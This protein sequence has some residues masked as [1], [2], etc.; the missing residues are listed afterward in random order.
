VNITVNISDAKVSADPQA[1][2]ATYSLGSCIGVT[3]WD[4]VTKVGG[5]L[6]FQLPTSSIDTQRAKQCPC[7]FADTG[8]AKLLQDVT[9]SGGEKND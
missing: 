6:H 4:P 9:S 7:M 3:L 8:F 2:L 5:M 1:V